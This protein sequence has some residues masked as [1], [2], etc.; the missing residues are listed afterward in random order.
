MQNKL[1]KL[2]VILVV[3][4]IIVSS[5]K[6][7]NIRQAGFID[8]N[9]AYANMIVNRI[10]NFRI[11]MHSTERSGDMM[12]LDTAIWNLEALIT[13]DKAYPDSASKDFKTM[14]SYYTL[15]LDANNM[16][17][18]AE[19]QQVYNLMLDTL[20]YQLSLFNDDVKFAVFSDVELIEV[21][22]NTAHIMA[23]NGYGSGFIYGLYWP[24]IADDDW[25]WGTLSGPLAGK[26]DGTEIGVSDGSDE[27]SWRL[28][29]PSAQPS[30]WKYT[31]IETVAVHFMNCTYNEPPQLPRVFSSLDGNH[32]M[33][34]EELTFFLEAAHWIIYDYN[35]LYNDSGWPI[36]IEDGEGARPEGKNFISIEI[37]DAFEYA[38]SR[39]FHHYH[40]TYGIPTGIIP[41]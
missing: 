32:C 9:T 19:V 12:L 20:N 8:N 29:N 24:F 10:D 31:D 35:L 4:L 1:N 22:G 6:K 7:D 37:I 39:N 30:T 41:D 23:L 34:N 11:Q 33:E 16:V 15:T 2:S 38:Y 5:C 25:I 14:K 18:E 27:L 36:V 21:V 13:Y 3:M 26:C 28:N 40:I 17:T